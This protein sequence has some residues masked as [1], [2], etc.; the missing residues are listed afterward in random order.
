MKN[1][2]TQLL[3]LI[4]LVLGL[5]SCVESTNPIY[6]DNYGKYIDRI[7]DTVW[8][9]YIDGLEKEK[10]ILKVFFKPNQKVSYSVINGSNKGY[11]YDD[12]K[13]RWRVYNENL[14]IS[15]NDELINL[16]GIISIDGLS[17]IGTW[18][19]NKWEK[20]PLLKYIPTKGKWSGK[21]KTD[22]RDFPEIRRNLY[23]N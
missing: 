21:S 15:F 2:L 8:E 13:D 10:M 20:I 16:R 3:L 17:V 6:G 11:T 5:T 1:K 19:N 22:L 18:K 7:S 23:L 14:Y 4:I 12:E 9:I